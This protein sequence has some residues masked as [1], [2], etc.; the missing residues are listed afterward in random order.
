MPGFLE[1][2]LSEYHDMLERHRNRPML[3]AAM[4]ACALAAAADGE[5]TFGERIRVD[6]I[7]STLGTLKVFDPHEGV[8]LFNEFTEAIF[9]SPRDGRERALEAVRAVTANAE[10]AGLLVRMCLAVVEAKGEKSLVE[11]IEIVML[12]GVLGVEPARVGLYSEVPSAD[13]SVIQPP[14]C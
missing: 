10:T 11:E 13:T 2:L 12:C 8:G 7:L 5:V 1:G 3:R 6:Q 4:A 14:V 9:E